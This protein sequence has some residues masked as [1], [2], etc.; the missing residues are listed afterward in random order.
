MDGY[1][2]VD[3]V[4]EERTADG[5]LGNNTAE[6][7]LYT[8]IKCKLRNY[9]KTSFDAEKEGTHNAGGPGWVDAK[10]K[11]VIFYAEDFPDGFPAFANRSLIRATEPEGVHTYRVVNIRGDY[12]FTKQ[13]DVEWVEGS[14]R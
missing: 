3:I 13:C 2:F 12:E 4:S 11:V 1:I 7:P 10:R 6:Q 14:E 9:A 8:Q 5:F